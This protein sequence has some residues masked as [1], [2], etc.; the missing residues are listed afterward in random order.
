MLFHQS[1]AQAMKKRVILQRKS[2]VRTC[3]KY[4]RL[5]HVRLEIFKISP[6]EITSLSTGMIGGR[7]ATFPPPDKLDK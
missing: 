5:L 7:V 4:Y 1:A 6:W 2:Y 3:F